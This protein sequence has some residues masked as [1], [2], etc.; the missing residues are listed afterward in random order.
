MHF[1]A[2]FKDEKFLE[3]E[4]IQLSACLGA[5]RLFVKSLI[6]FKLF[7]LG[8]VSMLQLVV[9]SQLRVAVPHLEA[10]FCLVLQSNLMH[11]IFK[12]HHKAGSTC[13]K[14]PVHGYIP[15]HRERWDKVKG[16]GHYWWH[17]QKQNDTIF[18]CFELL[19]LCV[20]GKH[21]QQLLIMVKSHSGYQC[22]C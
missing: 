12:A 21:F 19:L 8:L 22:V 13:S 1:W 17:Q 11:V 16:K 6:I 5:K 18:C 10:E 9:G 3:N 4:S 14:C 2:D 15:D 20:D 7:D